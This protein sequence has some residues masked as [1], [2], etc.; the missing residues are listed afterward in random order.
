M[1]CLQALNLNSSIIRMDGCKEKKNE[2]E[3]KI[4]IKRKKMRRRKKKERKK[5]KTMKE[6]KKKMRKMKIWS[7]G[8]RVQRE[9]GEKN[10][11]VGGEK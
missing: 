11:R 6:I 4:E 7:W 10:K 5:E 2:V 1:F 3:G 8:L 9:K